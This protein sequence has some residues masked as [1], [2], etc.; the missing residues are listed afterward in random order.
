MIGL[1]SR[2]NRTEFEAAI[3]QTAVSSDKRQTLPNREA[4]EGFILSLPELKACCVVGS[5]GLPW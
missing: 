4:I 2:L 1:M 5:T 3:E